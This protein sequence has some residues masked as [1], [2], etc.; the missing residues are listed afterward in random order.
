MTLK[1]LIQNKTCGTKY[2]N[3][4]SCTLYKIFVSKR[5]APIV[6]KKELQRLGLSA[7]HEPQLIAYYLAVID[8]VI[9]QFGVSALYADYKSKLLSKNVRGDFA[10]NILNYRLNIGEDFDMQVKFC[11]FIKELEIDE[12]W[13][14]EIYRFHGSAD[15]LPVDETGK[16]SLE[17]SSTYKRIDKILLHPKRYLVDKFILENV[18]D[19]RIAQYCREHLKMTV[20]HFDIT[21]YKK[22]FFNIKTL[23]IEEKIKTLEYEKN[24]LESLLKDVDELEEYSDLEIGEKTLLIADHNKDLRKLMITSN[25]NMMY[26]GLH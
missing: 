26:S 2:R 9:K 24:S 20:N 4:T 16:R 14:K 13:M 23:S 5:Y 22:S 12:L 10:K 21:A 19:S 25:I 11:K 17:A 6:I 18:P 3:E 1:K 8:P 7:P 15:N